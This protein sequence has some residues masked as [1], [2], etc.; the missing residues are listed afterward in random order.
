MKALDNLHS[1]GRRCT[2]VG[3]GLLAFA[4]LCG[5]CLAQT[6]TDVYN[7]DVT[8]GQSPADPGVLAQGRDGNFYTTIPNQL[9]FSG[10][11]LQITPSGLPA[12]LYTFSGLDGSRPNSGLTLGTDGNFYG[13]TVLGGSSSVGTAFKIASTGSLTTLHNFTGGSDGAYAYGTPIQGADGNLYGLTQFATAYKL[14]P[15]GAFTLL[16]TIPDRSF[17][18]LI[19]ATDGNFYGTTQHGGSFLQGT[20]FRMTPAGKITVVYNFDT[21]HG[22]VPWGSVVQGT[23]GNFYGT[24]TS[25][26]TGGGGVVF[27]LTPGGAITILHNFPASGTGDGNNPIAGLVQATDGNFYGACFA[28]GTLNNGVLFKISSTGVYSVLYNFDKTSG[29]SPES[30]LVQHT[31]GAIYAMALAGGA[32][33]YGVFYSLNVGLGPFVKIVQPFGKVGSPAEVLGQGFTGTSSVKI[34]GKAATF[35]VVSDT[36]LTAKVP[37]G[38][39]TGTLTVVTPSGT[40]NSN[41]KFRVTPTI[42]SFAPASGPVGTSVVLTGNSLTRATKVTFGGIA[43]AVF[44][45]N[46]D[47][48][49]TA[50]VPA[51]AM[52]GKIAITTPGGTATS[53]TSF[54]VTP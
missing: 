23:D 50:T 25:G 21:T 31:N 40:L 17:S 53:S 49:V 44:T 28:G 34:N 35:T 13:G 36:Y 54:T 6:Y 1:V 29:A 2:S 46:S 10:V 4:L 27:K 8:H 39:T 38:A 45:V 24:A 52:T 22:A 41:V 43:A 42:L 51:G 7:F 20:V 16:G 32:N 15:S 26:G 14:T 37:A 33:G 30:N 11:V 47:T 5:T 12:V 19:L 48:Q 3:L 9:A 18:P